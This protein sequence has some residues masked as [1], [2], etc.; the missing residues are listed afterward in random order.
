V[1]VHELAHGLTMA[2]FGRHVQRAGLKVIAIFPYAFVDTSEAWFESR[3]R[4]IA[5]SAA[6]PV[7]D[8][9]IGAIFALCALLLP[10]GIVRDI[11][12]NLAFAAYVGGFFNLNPFIERDGYHM[13]VDW[14]N[15]PGLRRRAK[16]QLERKLG[17]GAASTDSPVLARYSLF[18]L[19]WSVLAA[20]FAIGMSLRYEKIFLQVL[21]NKPVV[22][23]VMGT[24]WVAFFLP[25]LVV[26]GKP[27]WRRIRE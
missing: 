13:L 20:C 4:R 7:S 24:L 2:S 16:E 6:G 12:F 5:V 15:E 3:R 19:G 22:Y 14:L 1:S 25:V 8:F 10:A 21:D 26:L 17:G 11:F 27:V 9:S 23:G 18:G